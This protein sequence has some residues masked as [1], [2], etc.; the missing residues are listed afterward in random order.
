MIA[1]VNDA[2]RVDILAATEG[3]DRNMVEQALLDNPF[4][5]DDQQTPIVVLKKVS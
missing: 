1:D 5:N 3:V 4:G 2:R